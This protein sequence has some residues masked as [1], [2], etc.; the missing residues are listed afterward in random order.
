M[1]TTTTE[2]WNLT[3]K[4]KKSLQIWGGGWGGGKPLNLLIASLKTMDFETKTNF[5]HLID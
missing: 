2:V 1:H 5:T 3:Q 4:L